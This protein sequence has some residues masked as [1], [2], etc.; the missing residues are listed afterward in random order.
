MF[1]SVKKR[2]DCKHLLFCFAK[3]KLLCCVN[4]NL[5]L[6]LGLGLDLDLGLGLGLLKFHT[7]KR[8]RE[9]VGAQC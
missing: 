7:L 5:N 4:L 8:I 2:L 3:C 9:G 1:T 6:N